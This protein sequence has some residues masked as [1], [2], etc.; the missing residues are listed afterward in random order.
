MGLIK[1][2]FLA[3]IIAI[4]NVANMN[5]ETLSSTN[6]DILGTWC[7]IDMDFDNDAV[8]ANGCFKYTIPVPSEG[9]SSLGVQGPG[10]P[11]LDNNNGK[12]VDLYINKIRFDLEYGDCDS[13]AL[14]LFINNTYNGK[15]C[16]YQIIVNATRTL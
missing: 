6:S 3:V 16:H 15:P 4:L 9:I 1:N 10:R 5:A 12:T 2:Y 7:Y 8:E 14:E 13:V 11:Y